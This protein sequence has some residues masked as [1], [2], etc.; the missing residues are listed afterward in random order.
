MDVCL[1]SGGVVEALHPHGRA[2]PGGHGLGILELRSAQG[3][4][5]TVLITVPVTILG[6]LR[7]S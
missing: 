6:H 4:G 7:G 3:A 1:F 5:R 2:G